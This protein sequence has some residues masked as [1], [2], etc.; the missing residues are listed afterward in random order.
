M[1][2][3]DRHPSR[4]VAVDALRGACI[5]AI[6]L[7]H[8]HPF[9]P[10]LTDW[11]LYGVTLFFMISGY[12]M[13]PSLQSSSSLR[14]FLSKRVARLFPALLICGLLSTLIKR[15]TTVRPDRINGFADWIQSSV[16]LPTVDIPCAISGVLIG[17]FHVYSYPDGAYWTLATEFKFYLF[18]GLMYFV[19]SR[20]Y[21]VAAF[22]VI[23][24]GAQ[25]FWATGAYNR[26]IDEI[27]PYLPVFLS[28]FAI[29]EI[30]RGNRKSGLIGIGSS[31]MVMALMYG[32]EVKPYSMPIVTGS[33]LWAYAA[34]F[35]ILLA[36]TRLQLI[37]GGAVGK[38]FS[39]VGA[40]SYPLYLLH[41]DIGLVLLEYLRPID[42]ITVRLFV[43]PGIMVLMAFAVHK[44]VEYRWQAAL[45]RIFTGTQSAEGIREAT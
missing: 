23:L 39:F 19:V 42:G 28:G 20:R 8:Y 30:A 2:N 31:A 34:C 24:F 35:T 16:C 40:F 38:L 5:I 33:A 13:L 45:T 3:V 36:T 43:L 26:L 44:T 25:V 17:K 7:Y 18:I 15:V 10:G 41:Q 1:T 32:L 12:C 4:E 27:L 21:T 6:L 22:A 37:A 9:G 29:S 14:H 11:G